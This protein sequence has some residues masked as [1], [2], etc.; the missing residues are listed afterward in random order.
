MNNATLYNLADRALTTAINEA[1]T[2]IIGLDGMTAATIQARLAMGSGGTT[3]KVYIQTS[4]DQ[5]TT[6]IDVACLAFTTTGATKLVNLSGLTAKTAPASPT[7]GAM[8]DDTCLDGVLGDRLRAK[9]VTTGTYSSAVLS[10]RAA[11]R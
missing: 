3:A 5:G 7:D 9:I 1:Q 8:A 11:V 6:W 10:V 4:L 2:A